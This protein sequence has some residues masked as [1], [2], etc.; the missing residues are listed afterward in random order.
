MQLMMKAAMVAVLLAGLS[1][2]AAGAQMLA[3]A[4]IGGAVGVAGGTAVTLAVITARAR[5][6][7]EYLHA[8]EDLIHWQSLPM[9]AAPAAGVVF[10][11]AGEDELRGSIIGSV[12]G[13]ALGA[14]VGAGLGWIL[15]D[16]ADWPWAGGIMGGGAGLAV[17]GLLGGLLAWTEGDGGE[18]AQPLRLL[19]RLPL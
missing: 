18:E 2:S 16:E 14:G 8:R 17:G 3:R 4:A 13:L 10:G 6:Q 9:I 11:W 1:P 7:N 19:L 5:F 15:S 12:S